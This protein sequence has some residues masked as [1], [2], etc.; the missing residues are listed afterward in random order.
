MKRLAIFDFDGTIVDSAATIE[1]A[2]IATLEAIG[3][4][5]HDNQCCRQVIGLSLWEVAAELMP[6][7]DTDM[8]A[9][10]GHAFKT[11]FHDVRD[12][13]PHAEPV[14][15]G[16]VE[17]LDALQD[18]GWLL[19]IATGNTRRG[20]MPL[21]KAHELDGR[22]VSLQTADEHPSKP[23]PSMVGSAILDA[24]ADPSS[25]IVIGDTTF[26]VLM[27]RAAGTQAIGVTWGCHEAFDLRAAGATGIARH[28]SDVLTIARAL[29]PG[30]LLPRP[31]ASIRHERFA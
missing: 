13:R 26:D 19:A 31:G 6:D 15:D 21:L 27:A 17:L 28:P 10:F 4:R 30:V 14:F 1:Q 23:N 22:F 25:T 3:H 24:R 12:S 7:A 5:L 29:G 18:D 2:L 11:V 9:K 8:I 16:V 20:V